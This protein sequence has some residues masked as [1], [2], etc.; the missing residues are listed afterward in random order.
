MLKEVIGHLLGRVFSTV[1]GSKSTNLD[2][3]DESV[4]CFILLL[5]VLEAIKNVVFVFDEVNF[6][7]LGSITKESDDIFRSFP[8][9]S[10]RS[11]YVGE[12]KFKR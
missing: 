4:W 11:E 6:R 10:E 1:V 9:Y 3:T 2:V 12:D 8:A 7:E 5:E